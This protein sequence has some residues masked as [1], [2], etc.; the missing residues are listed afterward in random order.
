[1]EDTWVQEPVEALEVGFHRPMLELMPRSGLLAWCVPGL[2]QVQLPYVSIAGLTSLQ[3][4][5][6]VVCGLAACEDWDALVAGVDASNGSGGP[7]TAVWN[8]GAVAY[9]CARL[10]ALAAR[11]SHCYTTVL[12]I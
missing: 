12:P 11:C 5:Q 8:K 9:R 7:C 3:V 4:G 1:M 2:D 6:A 10:L